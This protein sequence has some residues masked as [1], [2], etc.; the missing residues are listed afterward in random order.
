M[1]IFLSITKPNVVNFPDNYIIIRSKLFFM[2]YDKNTVTEYFPGVT[3]PAIEF[4]QFGIIEA[5][6]GQKFFY[7]MGIYA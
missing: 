6:M 1:A 7:C 4:F 2:G 5:K 3:D